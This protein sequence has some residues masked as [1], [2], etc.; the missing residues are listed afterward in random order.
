MRPHKVSEFNFVCMYELRNSQNSDCGNRFDTVKRF[1]L[2]EPH[3]GAGKGRTLRSNRV[4]ARE[5]RNSKYYIKIF[6][7]I[8]ITAK[9]R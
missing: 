1:G 6:N 9:N 5:F 2:E 4:A 3:L 8:D 7:E